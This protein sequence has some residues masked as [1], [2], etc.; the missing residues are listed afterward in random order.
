MINTMDDKRYY[1]DIDKLINYAESYHN[2]K[3]CKNNAT[4]FRN[5]GYYHGYKG[6]R[7]VYLP[8]EGERLN[9]I[10][11][12][13]SDFSQLK[14]LYDFD[15]NLKTL[16]YPYV[17]FVETSIK[18]RILESLCLLV[19]SPD[20]ES[21]CA[22]LFFNKKEHNCVLN[23]KSNKIYNKRT[24]RNT[25]KK[26]ISFMCK[27]FERVSNGYCSESVIN[28]YFKQNKPLPIWAVFELL[29]LGD[30]RSFLD[31]ADEELADVV[32]SYMNFKCI[33]LT[34]QNND[35]KCSTAHIIDVIKPLRD[36]I[37]HNRAIYDVRFR[38][39]FDRKKTNHPDQYIDDVLSILN[40]E[41]DGRTYRIF[42]YVVFLSYVIYILNENASSSVEL[43]NGFRKDID[44]FMLNGGSTLG[45]GVINAILTPNVRITAA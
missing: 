16:L 39:K 6:Y 2:I 15:T 14:A 13:Y 26:Q 44:C 45:N 35:C 23:A 5:M 36:S 34:S 41:R 20:I 38:Q 17:M 30:I 18:N 8:R 33:E 10:I 40:M 1:K 11:I 43:L 31:S 22:Q 12:D 19:D 21:V 28:H 27:L 25:S 9:S 42:D 29:S 3:G 37:A 32:D 7:Y 24:N 4:D